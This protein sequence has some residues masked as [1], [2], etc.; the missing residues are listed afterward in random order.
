MT[1]NDKEHAPAWY[2]QDRVGNSIAAGDII[3]DVFDHAS[4]EKHEEFLAWAGAALG[5]VFD[6]PE[7]DEDTSD[8]YYQIRLRETPDADG[9]HMTQEEAM[10]IVLLMAGDWLETIDPSYV[11]GDL[12]LSIQEVK[13]AMAK[14]T[15]SAVVNP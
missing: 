8:G 13:E 6:H 10:R 3:Y 9:E 2:A 11:E 7:E 12:G 1:T 14:V 4:P 15:T 5:V